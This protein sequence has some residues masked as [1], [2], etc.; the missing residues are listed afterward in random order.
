MGWITPA[1]FIININM[2]IFEATDVDL[3]IQES[4]LASL[5]L[6]EL[7]AK[8]NTDPAEDIIF[9]RTVHS[10]LED[11]RFVL[12]PKSKK[13]GKKEE[14]W[15]T[16][17]NFMPFIDIGFLVPDNVD[18]REKF[19][20]S[21]QFESIFRHEFQHFLD[22]KEKR[23]TKKEDR[24]SMHRDYKAYVNSNVEYPAWFKQQAEPM[25][26]I[27][28]AAKNGESLD[29]LEKIEPDFTKFIRDGQHFKFTMNGAPQIIKFDKKARMKYLRDISAVHKAVVAIEGASGK[30]QKKLLGR[31]GQWLHDSI[32]FK[33]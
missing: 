1:H 21:G 32:G 13:Q 20:A 7:R 19:I 30:F 17:G 14:G 22:V 4:E 31:V 16:T 18:K 24:S 28:R 23:F 5:V 6:R 27:L 12:I 33:L 2:R 8:I 29:G 9:L 26:A 3:H 25:L 11:A 10:S 15:V